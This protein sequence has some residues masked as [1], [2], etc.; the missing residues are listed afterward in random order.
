[1]EDGTISEK[2]LGLFDVTFAENRSSKRVMHSTAN[3]VVL[4]GGSEHAV[5]F[6]V[7]EG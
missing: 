2:V 4:A 5:A 1:M 6:M 7:C 3:A